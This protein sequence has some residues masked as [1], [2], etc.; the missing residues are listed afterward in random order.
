MTG[1]GP[2]ETALSRVAL[3]VLSPECDLAAA[4]ASAFAFRHPG[5]AARI[6]GLTG[7]DALTGVLAAAVIAGATT[8]FLSAADPEI[9]SAVACVETSTRFAV[10]GRTGPG[11][12]SAAV[13]VF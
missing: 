4:A 8:R 2:R 13:L 12:F 7:E 11:R 3:E 6:T 5:P 10:L 1:E 9:G